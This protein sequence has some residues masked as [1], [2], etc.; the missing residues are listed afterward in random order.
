LYRQDLGLKELLRGREGEFSMEDA[1]RII[2]YVY[3]VRKGGIET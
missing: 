3:D 2:G 1:V